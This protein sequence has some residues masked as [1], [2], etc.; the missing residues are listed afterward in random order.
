MFF[1]VF[2]QHD[3]RPLR[4]TIYR[5]SESKPER[6]SSGRAYLYDVVMCFKKKYSLGESIY[7]YSEESAGKSLDDVWRVIL[8]VKKVFRPCWKVVSRIIGANGVKSLST[9]DTDTALDEY[10]VRERTKYNLDGDI[11]TEYWKS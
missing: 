9:D 5:R 3:L 1:F 4:S 10:E 11:K 2:F 8:Q 6:F 7:L